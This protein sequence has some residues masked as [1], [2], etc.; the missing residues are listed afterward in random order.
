MVKREGQKTRLHSPYITHRFLWQ[1]NNLI[2]VIFLYL[3]RVALFIHVSNHFK[4]F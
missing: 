2:C 4:E 1:K 3:L